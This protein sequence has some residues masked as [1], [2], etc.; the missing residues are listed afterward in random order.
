MANDIYERIY[1]ARQGGATSPAPSATPSTTTTSSN[2][3]DRIANARSGE[4]VKTPVPT[5]TTSAK[6]EEEEKENLWDKIKALANNSKEAQTNA[7]TN[8]A[9]Y[10]K[11]QAEENPDTRTWLQKGTLANGYQF[12]DLTKGT[13]ASAYDVLE[14][15][16]AG[17]LG[18]GEKFADATKQ[19]GAW[20]YGGLKQTNPG[21]A[22]PSYSFSLEDREKEK[23]KAKEFIAKDLYDEKALSKNIFGNKAQM[24]GLDTE[25]QSFLGEKTDALAQ[26][27]GQ[28]LGTAAAQ[29]AGVP[30]FLT[31]GLSS[32]GGALEEAYN[33]GASFRE[34]GISAAVTAAA[35]MLSEKISGGIK[36]KG[37]TLDDVL[38]KKLADV[39]TNKT[40][41]ILAQ[42]GVAAAGEGL[43]ELLS[44]YIS[45]IGKKLTYADDKTLADI[46]SKEEALESFIGGAILG[47]GIGLANN[48][49]N[50]APTAKTPTAN[51][52]Q[53]SPSTPTETQQ[54]NVTPEVADPNQGA[55]GEANISNE[56]VVNGENGNV[57]AND[58]GLGA[59]NAGF[60]TNE[61]AQT[62]TQ[63]KTITDSPYLTEEEKARFAP[64]T[65][66]RISEQE[67]IN[68]AQQNFYVDGEGKIVNLD[69]TLEDL[70]AKDIWNSIEQDTA[71]IAMIELVRRARETG[72]YTA[73]EALAKKAEA[74]GG[75]EVAR[76][77][78]ARLKWVSK[79]GANIVASALNQ[80]S[81][82]GG[83][84]DGD[85]SN[86]I[87][88]VAELAE[89]Y[90]NVINGKVV[91]KKKGNKQKVEFADEVG[92][93][94]VL[95]AKREVEGLIEL[96]RR[97]AEA[98]RTTGLFSKD[99]SKITEW[100]LRHVAES[101]DIQFLRDF[102]ANGILNIAT[103]TISP[104]AGKAITTYRRLAMLSK[105]TTIMRNLVSNGVFD[106][107][108]TFAR[109]IFVPLDMAISKRTGTRSVAF[110]KYYFSEAKRKGTMD[111]LAKSLLEVGLDVDAS[112][113][114]GRYE[115]TANRT[116]KMSGGT[117]SRLFSTWE[118]IGGYG[119]VSTDAAFSGGTQAE[120]Q[121]GIDELYNKGLIKDESLENAGETE[122]A[123]RT[124][125]DENAVTRAT[126]GMRRAANEIKIGGEKGVGLGTL[127]APFAKTP[128]NL[129]VRA[130][131][132]S[133]AGLIK[134]GVELADIFINAKKGTKTAAQQAQAIQD[135]GRGLTGSGLI[136]IAVWGAVA[137]VIKTLGYGAGED[138]KDLEAYAKMAGQYG[139]QLNASALKR[140]LLGGST[141]WQDGDTLLS[142]SF[143][144]PINAH[145]TT[146]AL[147]AEDIK[148]GELN[149]GNLALDSV[150]GALKSILDMPLMATAKELAQNYEYAEGDRMG[151]KAINAAAATAAG[152]VSSFVPN[153]VKGVAQGTDPIQRQSYAGDNLWEQT[154]NNVK[155][156]IP[157]LRQTVDAKKD[158]FGNEMRNEGGVLNF[159]NTN[160]LPGYV[161][162]YTTP[163]G[164]EVLSKIYELTGNANIYPDRKAPNTKTATID[165]KSYKIELDSEARDKYLTTAGNAYE[166]ILAAV[167]GSKTFTKLSADEAAVI[168]SEAQN[169]AN[170]QATIDAFADQGI[171]I[172]VSDK[173]KVLM[174]MTPTQYIEY[175]VLGERTPVAAT[176]KSK[177]E[178][179]QY[180]QA[181]NTLPTNLA[182]DM[183]YAGSEVNGK[184]FEAAVNAGVS[185]EDALAYYKALTQRTPNGEAPTAGEKSKRIRELGLDMA[186]LRAL[187]EAWETKV[188]EKK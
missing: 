159:L 40:L 158:S 106:I 55:S 154:L 65:H 115:S 80:L 180:E 156:S 117:I 112:G 127:L 46:F 25:Q 60:T 88:L 81:S 2:I 78:Q 24:L 176:Y 140:G 42:T 155:A 110:D 121:R 21:A 10:Y 151:E 126:L 20:S 129:A 183:I 33:E 48:V 120:V 162:H 15:V 134:G 84:T 149:L 92:D 66:E 52:P 47:G 131:E 59:A 132:Y 89:E 111:A 17:V 170:K 119:L 173:E 108:D 83:I 26:S 123:Y 31:T 53:I 45:A 36:F 75:T 4:S 147:I 87:A 133:P 137:G 23:D 62:P 187:D 179:Q 95:D 34:A 152:Q 85:K 167:S 104:D 86:A 181:I 56:G 135:L 102:A 38:T 114:L 16:G 97:T 186:T 27:G 185:L 146:G 96:I 64:G 54:A 100:A 13:A 157:G 35:E 128:T 51:K 63:N 14:N 99:F 73:A 9:D 124:F 118:K 168:L 153:I 6:K 136:A 188:E 77:L 175:L 39:I 169:F 150:E 164:N 172:K 1:A 163:E 28:L 138:D 5:P 141:E 41:N 82:N 43:E 30:W 103:D 177:P 58:D 18:L 101:G 178:W 74:A 125:Q 68:R 116:F 98:R 11:K 109:D 76:S 19:L 145:L 70:L 91:D 148:N 3:Y 12:G 32:Y 49:K 182:I 144:E 8:T 166:E 165:G 72:D 44:G 61:G 67:S 94:T 139:T 171:N 69:A 37:N 174:D 122:A 79:N 105:A 90:D 93:N 142:I 57:N 184:K 50:A 71:Q 107:V 113:S 7:Y 143:L 160:I 29:F 130:V 161:T 22:Q